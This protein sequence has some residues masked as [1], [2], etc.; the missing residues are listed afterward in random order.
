MSD[1]ACV[2]L[3]GNLG[4]RLAHLRAALDGVEALDGVSVAAV[5]STYESEPVGYLDQPLFLNAAV[6]LHCSLSPVEL[7]TGLFSVEQRQGRQ[8]TIRW[9]PRTLDLDLLL[10]GDRIVDTAQLQLPHPRLLERGFVL[11]PLLEIAP[12]LRHPVTGRRLAE[13]AAE[14]TGES[15]LRMV[16]PLRAAAGG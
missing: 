6:A 15:G 4:D 12:D 16:G 11:V 5:S 13:H 14:L 2:G 10:W 7:L 3:G 8:R 1:L 9:G